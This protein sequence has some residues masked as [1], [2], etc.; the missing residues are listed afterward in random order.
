[1]RAVKSRN[2][3]PEM[4]V[5]QALF[6]MGYR[7]RLHRADLPG[8]PDIVFPGR[9]KVIF[10]HGCFWHG[11]SCARGSR[12]PKANSEYWERKILMN[13][14]RDKLHVADL[15]AHGWTV[16]ALWECEL[17]DLTTLSQ[18]LMLFLDA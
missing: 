9:H 11:H 5:R 10:V 6:S 1:M 8:K 17:R 18:Q 13:R 2:T 7:Y 15:Q 16:L 3:K 12:T 14:E 4:L